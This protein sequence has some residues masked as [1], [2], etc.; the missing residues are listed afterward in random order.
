MFQLFTFPVCMAV[1]RYLPVAS[2][3]VAV[4]Y[5]V[6]NDQNGVNILYGQF[7][8][9]AIAESDASDKLWLSASSGHECHVAEPR[10][11]GFV[12][13]CQSLPHRLPTCAPD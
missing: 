7:G 12:A 5:F 9:N 8:Q 11:I 2:V 1:V 10:C 6:G 13:R 3:C 4:W